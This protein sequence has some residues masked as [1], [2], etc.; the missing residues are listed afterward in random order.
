[1]SNPD[2]HDQLA[3]YLG[4]EM[5]EE[6]RIRFETAMS[7]DPG[8]AAEAASLRGALEAM[9]SLPAEPGPAVVQ[10]APAAGDRLHSWGGWGG[11]VLKYAAVI[12][13]AFFIGYS[14]RG[15]ASERSA[16]VVAPPDLTDWTDPAVMQARTLSPWQERAAQAYVRH[17]GGSTFGRSLVVLAHAIR[18]P[19]E[20]RSERD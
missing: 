10:I 20:K 17:E 8:L 4:D 19:G 12:A 9:R 7:K 14:V 1:M 11:A 15:P 5:D 2:H 18:E 6:S 3:A 16:A 13:A